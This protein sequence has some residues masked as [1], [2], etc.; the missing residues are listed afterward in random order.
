MHNQ[1]YETFAID[2]LFAKHGHTVIKLPPY[3][4][5]LNPKKKFGVM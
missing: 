3:H 1:Q 4:P 2:G 5:D